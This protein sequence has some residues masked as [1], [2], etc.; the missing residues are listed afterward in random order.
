MLFSTELARNS[1]SKFFQLFFYAHR[2]IRGW[3]VGAHF[4]YR[5]KGQLS[6]QRDDHFNV[7]RSHLYRNLLWQTRRPAYV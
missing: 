3:D 1:V 2:N 7:V 4:G 5:E 6:L